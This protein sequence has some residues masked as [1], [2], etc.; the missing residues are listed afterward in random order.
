MRWTKAGK[1]ETVEEHPHFTLSIMRNVLSLIIK[2]TNFLNPSIQFFIDAR[3]LL[4]IERKGMH[5]TEVYMYL[6]QYFLFLCQL[7]LKTCRRY[8]QNLHLLK[9]SYL[10]AFYIGG[11]TF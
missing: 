11:K 4:L 6:E 10:A 5:N 1:G 8:I 7:P 3:G 9:R 2:K